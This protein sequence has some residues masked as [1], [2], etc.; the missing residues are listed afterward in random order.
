MNSAQIILVSCDERQFKVDHI[1]A[2]KSITIKNLIG[3]LNPDGITEDFEIPLPN[4]KGEALDK[5]LEWFKYHKD[6]HFK[7]KWVPHSDSDDD[8]FRKDQLETIED[9]DGDFLKVDKYMLFDIIV[10]AN[11]LDIGPLRSMACNTVADMIRVRSESTLR[12]MFFGTG[13]SIET[14]ERPTSETK[15]TIVEEGKQNA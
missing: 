10:A 6:T 14:D 4:V 2:E 5:V 12:R 1:V 8:Y 11:Y 9:W 13:S 15:V 3:T 7:Y